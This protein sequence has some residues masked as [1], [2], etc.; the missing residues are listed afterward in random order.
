MIILP[1]A[2]GGFH[3]AAVELHSG[4]VEGNG[5]V[6]E[7]RNPTIFASARSGFAFSRAACYIPLPPKLVICP[8][9]ALPSLH[10]TSSIG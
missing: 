9:G 10:P 6:W 5:V 7:A 2:S 3:A 1:C 4:G 8:L